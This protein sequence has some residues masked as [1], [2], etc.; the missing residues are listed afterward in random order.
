MAWLGDII[1]DMQSTNRGWTAHCS[2]DLPEQVES[3]TLMAF[4]EEQYQQRDDHR[5]IHPIKYKRLNLSVIAQKRFCDIP[6]IL[7]VTCV[8]V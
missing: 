4:P 7:Q 1:P 3:F 5:I 2:D 6:M 8:K